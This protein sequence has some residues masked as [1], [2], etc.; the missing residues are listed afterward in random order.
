[1]IF[2]FIGVFLL[3]LEVGRFLPASRTENKMK[4]RLTEPFSNKQAKIVDLDNPLD[5]IEI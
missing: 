5:S 2:S 1:M 4:N 3:G